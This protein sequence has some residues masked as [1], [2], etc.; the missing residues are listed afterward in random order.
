VE[1]CSS[2]SA[3]RGPC[4]E[5]IAL[6]NQG[7]SLLERNKVDEAE[8]ILQRSLVLAMKI[9]RPKSMADAYSCLA[10]FPCGVPDGVKPPSSWGRRSE[11]NERLGRRK[12]LARALLLW[13]DARQLFASIGVL[14]KLREL[15]GLLGETG[16]SRSVSR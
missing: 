13:R 8:L 7:L 16:V 5:A 9:G 11:I 2:L 12:G 15:D 6:R 4:P 3:G 14:H 10:R 1:Y